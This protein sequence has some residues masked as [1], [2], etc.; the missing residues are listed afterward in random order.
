MPLMVQLLNSLAVYSA[1]AILEGGLHSVASIKH[2]ETTHQWP[3][4][5]TNGL[6]QSRLDQQVIDPSFELD[7]FIPWDLMSNN[8]F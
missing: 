6:S 1:L 4:L 2:Q 3:K 8:Y 5:F 7:P